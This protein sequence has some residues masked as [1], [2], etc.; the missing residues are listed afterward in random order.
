MTHTC[1]GKGCERQVSAD[2]LACR[3]HWFQLPKELRQRIWDTWRS[4]DHEGHGDA[5][6]EAMAFYDSKEAS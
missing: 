5:V 6:L 1:P 4:D 3:R 2:M